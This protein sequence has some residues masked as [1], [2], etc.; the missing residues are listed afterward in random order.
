MFECN[1]SA[2]KEIFNMPFDAKSNSPTK[3]SR[4]MLCDA[5]GLGFVTPLPK[6][7][8]ISQHYDIPAYY[9]HGNDHIPDI[10]PTIW[11]RC[12]IHLAWRFDYGQEFNPNELFPNLEKN[13]R[14][15]DIGCG[16][17]NLLTSLSELGVQTS[18]IEPDASARLQASNLGHKVYAGTA[19]KFPSEF[20][21]TKFDIVIMTHVLEHCLEPERALANAQQV[22][23]DEGLFYCEV[24][25][26]GSSYFRKYAHISE[27]LDIPRH[28]YFFKKK[29][30]ESTAKRAGLE[31]IS[32]HYHGFTRHFTPGWKQWENKIFEKL[33]EK[34][35]QPVCPARSFVGDISLLSSAIFSPKKKK[36]DSIGFLAKR[37]D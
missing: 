2:A 16:A 32:W 35:L 12:L 27:M 3:F 1:H 9:T 5:C 22:L 6:E 14:A 7:N 18:G 29:S 17:G 10:V 8:E 30:L 23:S 20:D 26:A 24:P 31:I 19:E 36:Y 34:G 15:L 25:N 4:F 33:V 21:G 37:G 28:L 11:D 13:M